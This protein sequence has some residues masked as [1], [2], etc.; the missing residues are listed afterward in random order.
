LEW[1][2]EDIEGKDAPN[3]LDFPTFVVKMSQHPVKRWWPQHWNGYELMDA[4]D[5]ARLERWGEYVLDRPDPAV[6]WPP[7]ETMGHWNQADAR[8]EATAK[9]KGFWHQTGGQLPAS[10]DLTYQSP[11]LHLHFKLE[12]T[13]FKH[14][15]LFPEQ[16]VNWE[17]IAEHV[18]SGDKFLN[19]FAY[20][21]GA[22]LAARAAG[23][24]VTHVDS[25]RQVVDWTRENME[26]SGLDGIRWV[27]EDALK[28]AEREVRRSNRY[29]GIVLD[30]PT[31]GL[32]T[33]G[34]KWRL[35]D[36]I[37]PLCE[38]VAQL[39]EP[40][41]FII[42]NTYSGISPTALEQLWRSIMPDAAF[43]SGE[44]C[45]KTRHDAL[46]PTGSLVRITASN[47]G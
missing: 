19:L 25:I 16:A 14:V 11:R 45:L 10:W 12:L 15:G 31:W 9:T 18:K 6:I 21:G 43:E 5:G 38:I 22:S 1:V 47:H 24:D 40:G 33:K 26:R 44:L 27:V 32:G 36:Q 29:K 13:S 35:E 4:G 28:F 41:G 46:V 2:E 37:R 3:R 8:F 20:T 39:I 7:T 17:Y 34:A 30:P 23:A 42:M